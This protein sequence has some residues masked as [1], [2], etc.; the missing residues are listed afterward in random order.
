ML[1]N[2]L[3]S[4]LVIIVSILISIGLAEVFLRLFGV[5]YGNAPIEADSVLHHVHPKNYRFFVHDPAG[6]YGGFY[7]AYD[8]D[9]YRIPDPPQRNAKSQ[10]G[11]GVYFLG[12]S[13]TEA[14]QVSWDES[15][16]GK[17]EKLPSIAYVRNMG[18]S[19]YSPI[20]YLIQYKTALQNIRDVDVVIQLYE[21]DFGTDLSM[22]DQLGRIELEKINKIDGG[23]SSLAIKVLR[24][25]Y[26]ARLIRKVQLQLSYYFK[27][28]GD[29]SSRSMTSLDSHPLND[30]RRLT[31]DLLKEIKK[32]SDLRGIRLH[33]MMIPS[34]KLSLQNKCCHEDEL[35]A[36][37]KRF[38]IES[39]ISFI[40]LANYFSLARNQDMLFFNKDIHLTA[41]GHELVH[42]AVTDHLMSVK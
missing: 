38:A 17:I 24:H 1:R 31:Y 15:F 20:F 16:A 14:N 7:V 8:K 37:V 5:G 23:N 3:K 32:E 28:S 40:D 35:H 25:S 27:N 36:D 6:E 19:S 41:S 26:L 2:S 30:N 13:F 12:D 21:N 11:R 9:G 39:G 22:Y 10:I 33:L 29:D 18:V 42:Q 34:K 4:L